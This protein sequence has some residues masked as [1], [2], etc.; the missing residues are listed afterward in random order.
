M[1]QLQTYVIVMEGSGFF[2]RDFRTKRAHGCLR[3]E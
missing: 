3:N 2:P 1:R